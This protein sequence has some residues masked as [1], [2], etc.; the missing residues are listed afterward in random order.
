VD[1]DFGSSGL[2]VSSTL[3]I[4]SLVSRAFVEE[5][6]WISQGPLYDG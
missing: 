2:R 3:G 4:S 5:S 1:S 6:V